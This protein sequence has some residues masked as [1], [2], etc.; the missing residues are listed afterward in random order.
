MTESER[1]LNN[2]NKL[3]S[4]HICEL[5]KDKGAL[6]DEIHDLKETLAQTI[7]NDK[8]DYETLKLHDEEEIAQRDFRIKELEAQI[9]QL[10]YLHNEDVSTIKLLNEQVKKMKECANCP[11]WLLNQT[12][13]NCKDCEYKEALILLRR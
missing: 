3:L 6:T 13:K 5:L 2:Q 9:E 4:N 11:V 8:V 10:T 1:E 12:E 7:E